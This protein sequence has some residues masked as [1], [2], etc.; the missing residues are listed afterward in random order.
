[1]EDEGGSEPTR[2]TVKVRVAGSWIL[3]N[4]SPDSTVKDLKSVLQQLTNVL[5]GDQKL[6][7]KGKILVD[8][9]T[10]RTS[11][12][13]DGSKIMLI[14]PEVLQFSLEDYVRSK[15]QEHIEIWKSTGVVLL[16][17]SNL[18]AIP[19]AVWECG[20]SVKFLDLSGNS[21][22]EVPARISHLSS[23]HNLHLT[24]NG[25][26][27]TNLSWE[28]IESLKSL[29]ALSLDENRLTILPSS[30]GVLTNLKQLYIANNQLTSLPIEIGLLKELERLEANNNR[31]S[32]IPASI[33]RCASLLTIDISSNLLTE[34]PDTLSKLKNLKE[35]HLRNNGGLTSLPTTIFRLCNQLSIL[36]VDGTEITT[37]YLRQLDGWN[38][39]DEK[40]RLNRQRQQAF[41]E[42]PGYTSDRSE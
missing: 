15:L 4:V 20:S 27:D 40:V 26:E 30:L 8:E 11:E 9:M 19:D 33:C 35:L 31:L 23:L 32:T 14:P 7:S 17:K 39:F 3:F 38:E 5:P 6:I 12:V 18:K 37:D 13:D 21:L 2:I 28:G 41:R 29:R 24:A 16:S 34:L 1:M 22:E 42:E 25:I 36:D 10:F